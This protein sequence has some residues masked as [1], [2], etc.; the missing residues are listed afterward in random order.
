MRYHTQRTVELIKLLIR[1]HSISQV[2]RGKERDYILTPEERT[3]FEQLYFDPEDLEALTVITFKKPD[4][5]FRLFLGHIEELEGLLI[6]LVN[7]LPRLPHEQTV[8]HRLVELYL[9]GCKEHPSQR[10]EYADRILSLL[11]NANKKYDNNVLLSLFRMY[12]FD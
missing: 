10:E 1:A 12:D 5:F 7:D 6:Y 8:F 11:R 2:V 4:E 9:E 3:L